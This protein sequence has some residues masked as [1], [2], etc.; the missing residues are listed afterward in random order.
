MA[1][2]LPHSPGLQALPFVA[3]IFGGDSARLM[4]DLMMV[5]L[6][7]VLILEMAVYCNDDMRLKGS[8]AER[9]VVVV[10]A[11][12]TSQGTELV[13]GDSAGTRMRQNMRVVLSDLR[14][15]PGMGLVVCGTSMRQEMR[16]VDADSADM[17]TR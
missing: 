5:P 4:T 13:V 17:R 15:K 16:L 10:E 2:L 12:R 1:L 7:L 6:P 8:T 14:T 3:S 9:E 11:V